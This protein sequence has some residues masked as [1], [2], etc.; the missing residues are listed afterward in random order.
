MICSLAGPSPPLLKSPPPPAIARSAPL[1]ATSPASPVDRATAASMC[2]PTGPGST[3]A[4]CGPS[5]LCPSLSAEPAR[6]PHNVHGTPLEDPAPRHPVPQARPV[7]RRQCHPSARH[8]GPLPPP[9]RQPVPA[10]GRLPSDASGRPLARRPH[11]HPR[12]PLNWS[13]L[14]ILDERGNAGQAT[15]DGMMLTMWARS[16]EVDE[17]IELERRVGVG[18]GSP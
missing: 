12:I 2:S 17:S 4:A 15:A 13:N 9:R 1:F 6:C 18:G 3:P 11:A 7:L 8:R 10:G 16:R 14:H 5:T